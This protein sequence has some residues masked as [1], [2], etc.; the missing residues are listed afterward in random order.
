MRIL[1]I[2]FGGL[3]DEILFLPTLRSIRQVHAD[4]EI[5]L[6]TEPRSSAITLLSNLIDHNLV[7][8]IKKRPL[9]PC[10][11]IAL[12]K[13]LRAGKYDLV[14]SSGSS[15]RVALLLYAGGIRRRIG[16][17]SGILSRMLLSRAVR[18]NKEQY[19]AYM[20]HDLVRGLDI[21]LAPALP[22]IEVDD[23]ALA[24]M[25]IFLQGEREKAGRKASGKLV[26]IHP[27]ASRLAGQKGI[28]KTWAAD[29]WCRL[30]ERLLSLDC[31]VLLCGGPDDDATI[32]DI[33]GAL[34]SGA[35]LSAGLFINAYG[36][37]GSIKDLSALM[38]LAHLVICVDSAPM[39]MA[40]A[41]QK[42]LVAIFGPTDPKKL[43]VENERSVALKEDGCVTE[44]TGSGAGVRVLLETVYQAARA[45]LNQ[46]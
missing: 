2:N 20:Y 28:F 11:Y 46:P 7:F 21:D 17:D 36:K 44:Q 1:A 33:T 3:G 26:L 13:L 9:L 45:Q 14:L 18:L 39:H 5:T 34:A 40:H 6:L 22:Q 31:E 35:D 10:D 24:S 43:L 41:L 38:A 15:P 25:Q 42:R 4:W 37:T 30:V 12:I 29:N 32:R 27:G 23:G 8:D 16:Y 19:A